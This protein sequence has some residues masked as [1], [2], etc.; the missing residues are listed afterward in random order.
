MKRLVVLAVA[1]IGLAAASPAAATEYPPGDDLITVSDATP[2]P[3]QA[4]T[5]EASTFVPGTTVTVTLLPDAVLGTPVAD[6]NGVVTLDV[7]LSAT[8]ALGEATIEA[9]GAGTAGEGDVLVLTSTVDVVSCDEVAP[10]TTPPVT[11]PGGSGGGGDL[12]NTGSDSTMTLLKVGGGLAAIGGVL[13][14]LAAS[15]RRRGVPAV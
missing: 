9:V 15:R 5:V 6:E 1:V 13:V 11:T 12:P 10:T 8:Q 2:C 14:A 3:G 4:F 7:T